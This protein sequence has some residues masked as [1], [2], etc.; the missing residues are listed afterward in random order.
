MS[1]EESAPSATVLRTVPNR[2]Y[3]RKVAAILVGVACFAVAY[4]MAMNPRWGW[5]IVQEYLFDS[6]V[7]T[8]VRNTV[9][10]TV[11]SMIASMVVGVGIA[12]MRLSPN[13]LISWVA[14]IY[15]WFFRAVPL[16]VLVLFTYYMAALIPEI[17]IGLPSLEPIVSLPTN[18]L[19]N[20]FTAATL[21]IAVI[22]G[23][24]IGEIFRG[25]ILGVHAGQLEA[26]R[27]LGMPGGLMMRRVVLPQAIRIVAP[28]LGNQ[29]I[30]LLKATS[31]VSVVGYAEL[32]TS[33]QRI[34][35]RNFEQI[36]LLI[37]AVFWYLVLVTIAQGFQTLMERRVSAAYR[38]KSIRSAKPRKDGAAHA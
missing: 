20:Q 9:T 5:P 13:P 6:A 16:L 35:A 11:V 12:V 15:V 23:A 3:G 14:G 38:T 21:A 32:L 4:S 8:G 33:V 28:S 18:E 27:S 31:I 25:G 37:V 36:P 2:H 17:N 29:F 19:L 24:Y 7:I 26:A 30:D 1:V 10:L 34:Y 22:G